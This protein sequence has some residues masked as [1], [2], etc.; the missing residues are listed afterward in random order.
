LRQA[1]LEARPLDELHGDECYAVDF[2]GF[3]DLADV[4]MID[5][6][7]SARFID[8]ARAC[9]GVGLQFFRE[10]FERDAAAQARIFGEID[11]AHAPVPQTAQNLVV[12]DSL[13]R[14]GRSLTPVR[15]PRVTWAR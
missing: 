11:L 9:S 1:F 7:R 15:R 10:E 12:R 4:R 13:R 2:V 14:H 6:G 3:E 8:E 5:G